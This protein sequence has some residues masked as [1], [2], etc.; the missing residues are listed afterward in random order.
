MTVPLVQPFPD[1]P[2]WVAR[3]LEQLRGAAATNGDT[4]VSGTIHRPWDPAGCLP[5]QRK[6]LW[7]WLDEVAMW[8]NHEYVWQPA[9]A[10]PACWPAHPAL[11]HELA[12]LACQRVV[13]VT[14]TTPQ[15][16]DEWHRLA[17]PTF[18][19]RLITRL[20]TGCPP[21]RH[22]AWPGRSRHVEFADAEAAARRARLFAADLESATEDDPSAAGIPV[23]PRLHLYLGGADL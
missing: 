15:L 18:T 21:G 22:T 14:A 6:E 17:L 9:G 1:P 8:I 3:N 7:P 23:R 13:A 5:Q 16:I 19:T 11:V 4:L 10:I 20:G 12:V 2:R